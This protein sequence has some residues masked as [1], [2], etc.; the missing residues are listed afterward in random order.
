MGCKGITFFLLNKF[1]RKSIRIYFY[2]PLH[3][4]NINLLKKHNYEKEF[5][6]QLCRGFLF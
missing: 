4:P 2:L 3:P 5:A 6:Y 1:L